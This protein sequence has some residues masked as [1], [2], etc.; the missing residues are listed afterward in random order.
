MATVPALTDR[1]EAQR[2]SEVRDEDGLWGD[3]RPELREA[4]RTS[5]G[6]DDGG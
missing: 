4:V 6:D 2:W 3:L 1:T 5:L